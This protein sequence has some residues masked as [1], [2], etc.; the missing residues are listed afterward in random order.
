MESK[1]LFEN[2]QELEHQD[3][4]NVKTC[5]LPVTSSGIFQR[6]IFEFLVHCLVEVFPQKMRP[7]PEQC[8][9]FLRMPDAQAFS[10]CKGD[11]ERTVVEKLL[12][13][14]RSTS[15]CRDKY[16]IQNKT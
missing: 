10:L 8:V 14:A 3:S 2:Y 5:I 16:S 13:N 15:I 4:R 11:E 12:T 6:Q 1:G 9:H 7:K